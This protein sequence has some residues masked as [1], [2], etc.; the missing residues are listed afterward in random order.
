MLDKGRISSVQLLMLLFIIELAT[1]YAL[2]ITVGITGRDAWFSYMLSSFYGLLVAGVVIALATRFPFQTF[3][4]YLPDVVG[5]VLGKLLA[6]GYAVIFIHYTSLILNESTNFIHITTYSLTPV[7]VLDLFWVMAAV[8]GAYLGIECIARQNQLVYPTFVFVIIL[9]IALAA[10]DV[11]FDNLK[12]F[13]ENGF[14]PVIKGV[15]VRSP[16]RGELFLLLMLFPYLNQKH[17]AVKT[18]ILYLGLVTVISTTL[19]LVLLG[20]FGD[21][22]TAHLIFP[23]DVLARYISVANFLERMEILI[24][25]VWFAG[26][27]VKLAIFYH[28]AGIATANTLGLKSYRIT[29]IPIAITTIIISRVL[30]GTS[31]ELTTFLVN[32]FPVYGP[33]VELIIPALILLIAVIRKKRER[34]VAGQ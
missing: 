15:I 26:V 7:L 11:H 34:P 1:A 2:A 4:E 33:V 23:L 16:W 14:L 22:V 28:T 32:I 24:I 30:Y 5:K 17:E 19:E 31:Q 3:T 6:A 21:L 10:K 12:P 29:L 18:T 8:Y 25:F 27:I 9:I 20:V 13:L